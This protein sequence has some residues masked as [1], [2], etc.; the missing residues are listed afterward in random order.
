V[1]VV[2]CALLL[3]VHI[4]GLCRTYCFATWSWWVCYRNVGL[5]W[6]RP[7]TL[8]HLGVLYIPSGLLLQVFGHVCEDLY[9]LVLLF[10]FQNESAQHALVH[11]RVR[12]PASL[13]I[14]TISRH[15]MRL[16]VGS[17]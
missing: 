8:F 12:L 11:A 3:H 6:P 2:I 15:A 17:R 5:S 1:L 16:T 4:C 9:D 13:H 10:I 7:F 14:M